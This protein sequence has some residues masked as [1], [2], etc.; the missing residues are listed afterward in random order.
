MSQNLSRPSQKPKII[1]IL[2]PTASGK[3]S[4]SLKIALRLSSGQAQKLFGIKGAE[5]ISADSRQ[6]YRGLDI[7]TAKP[8]KAELK[9]IKHYLIDSKNPD[10]E[11]TVAHYK[12]DAT[13]T[14]EKVL[15]KNKLPILVGGTGLYVKAVID[16]LEIPEVKPNPRLRKKLE[17]ELKI[18][19]LKK[20]L[21]FVLKIKNKYII[22][23]AKFLTDY[24]GTQNNQFRDAA[25]VAK[26]KKN[27]VLGVA[28]LDGI[29]WF[30][31]NAYMHKTTKSLKGI[32]LSAL[33][34]EKFIKSQ[35]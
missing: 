26:I 13:F 33:L 6:I 35:K 11:Y 1:V 28:V 21:D 27:N 12:K 18:K 22:G 24:G 10:E 30:K 5:I 14:I 20:G 31:S 29:V 15:K 8:T 19:G 17:K 32:A 16:N 4:L 2:G 3:T 7:G 9:K 23:E 34:L 25:G